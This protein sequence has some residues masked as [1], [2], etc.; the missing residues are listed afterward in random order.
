MA[1]SATWNDRLAGS[2]EVL[3]LTGTVTELVDIGPGPV[4][5]VGVHCLHFL[6]NNDFVRLY[7]SLTSSGD[8]IE[9]R[10]NAP[11]FQTYK[12]WGP[13]G[14]VFSPG[15]SVKYQGLSFDARCRLYVYYR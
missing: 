11:E 10:P 4:V 15:L 3:Y 13:N 14:L 2:P 12:N 1:P 6:E 9:L 5:V 7:R 8:Y